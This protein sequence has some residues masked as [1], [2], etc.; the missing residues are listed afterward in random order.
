MHRQFEPEV[1][2]EYLAD[3]R[4]YLPA[5]RKSI[6]A[7]AGDGHSPEEAFRHVHTIRG[8]AAMLGLDALGEV[9]L[10]LEESLEHLLAADTAEVRDFVDLGVARLEQCLTGLTVGVPVPAALVAEVRA[11]YERVAHLLGGDPAPAAPEDWTPDQLADELP[12]ELR[13]VFLLEAADHFQSI[14]ALLPRLE[15]QPHNQALVQEVRRSVHTLKG[16]AAMVG[17][18]EITRL[19]HRMEDYLDNLAEGTATLAPE[20]VRLL[21]DATDSLES[22][23]AGKCNAAA[24]RGLYRRF[25]MLVV[26]AQP[27]LPLSVMKPNESPPGTAACAAHG[28]RQR[29]G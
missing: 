10:R 22:L 9:A 27:Q 7:G 6:A 15:Q 13:E 14:N 21:Y 8:G 2:A 12:A 23:A 17:F 11:A 20:A 5:I 29:P 3:A 1:I 24:L 18:Q 28:H 26:P 25:G 16:A 19:T 4:S